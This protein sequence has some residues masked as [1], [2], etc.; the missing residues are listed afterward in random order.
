MADYDASIGQGDSLQK[1]AYR[2]HLQGSGDVS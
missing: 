2:R 1:S